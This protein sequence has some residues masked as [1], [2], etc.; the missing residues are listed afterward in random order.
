[1]S[2]L[3]LP[4]SGGV[5]S[6][7]HLSCKICHKAFANVYRLQRHMISHDESALL[8]KF[9]CNQCDKAF[10]FKHHLK[11]HVRI[12]SGEKPFGCDNCGKRFSHSG[13]YSSHMTSKKCISMG[14]K[15]NPNRA[16]LKALEKN[17]PGQNAKRYNANNGGAMNTSAGPTESS[18]NVDAALSAGLPSHMNYYATDASDVAMNGGT[19]PFYPNI[20]Q[21]YDDYNMNAMNAALLAAFPHP[22]YSL[23]LNPR[24]SPYNIQRL[25]ELTAV[26]QQH[27]HQQQ[28]QQQQ[29]VQQREEES[30]SEREQQQPQLEEHS[31]R[32]E[33]S[34]DETNEEEIPDEPKLVMDL[35]ESEA[36]EGDLD[37][38]EE[39][40]SQ[41]VA[42]EAEDHSY[43]ID[44]EK[45]EN[46]EIE[47]RQDESLKSPALEENEQ[48]NVRL[49][50]N[51]VSESTEQNIVPQIKLEENRPA[52]PVDEERADQVE[53]AKTMPVIKQELDSTVEMEQSRPMETSTPTSKVEQE[54]HNES[55]ACNATEL[56]CS[57]C[58]TQF[59]HQTELVQ[60]EK[61]LCGFIKQELQ[62]SY[63]EQH[64]QR[65]QQ[66]HEEELQQPQSLV[67][68][69][70]SMDDSAEQS[71]I[72]ATSLLHTSDAEDY[73]D[74]RDSHSRNDCNSEGS[75]RKVRVRT[76]I[77]EEQQQQLKQHYA[78]NAR[79]SREEFRMIAAR[80]QLDARVVQ[81]WF[82][83]NRSRERKMQNYQQANGKLPLAPTEASVASVS[84]G[85]RTG[86]EQP[87]DLSLKRDWPVAA[88]RNGMQQQHSPLYGIAPM[89]SVS[90]SSDFTEAINLSR[91]MSASM[92]PP[93]SLSPSSAAS[94]P[95]SLKQHA[96]VYFG[97]PSGSHHFQRRTPSP[98]E[99]P[100]LTQQQPIA[101]RSVSNN[102]NNNSF[103]ASLAGHLPPYMLPT[104]AQ[105]SMMPMDA[106][107]RMTPGDYACNPLINS[108]KFPDYRGTSL[109]PGGSEKRSWRDDDSRISHDDDYIGGGLLPKPKR[110]KAE[111]HGHAGDPDLPFV[112]DQC[113]KAFA[114]Q[115]SL[116]RHKYEHSGQRPYQC[117]DCP[118]A[119][120]HKHH[121]TEHKRLH[122]GEKPFQ[123]SKCFKRFSHSGSYSQ[124]MNHRYSYCKPYRE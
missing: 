46:S 58:D 75:E 54:S 53:S 14:M 47:A 48:T 116:A 25:L 113:D 27:Q 79:P 121:L 10:K 72:S 23:G 95:Q 122:S 5:P 114:K 82:Q 81:V 50:N 38:E 111:T 44:E 107:F 109:S 62:H 36:K 97:A 49:E 117:V 1:M 77:T 92:S 45:I 17:A 13:S 16:M 110:P 91:K 63:Q 119:F 123:C 39:V 83:N 51:E 68:S 78:M 12:H 106:I 80:L 22:F 60:H 43:L 59:N 99:A 104:G 89:Q 76:A 85:L 101:P 86:E 108:I 19:P 3:L 65:L 64:S 102:N 55:S 84:T 87:L 88:K 21:K 73:P 15:L 37:D 93:S 70:H 90:G 4:S 33:D 94:V 7:F 118:K 31:E 105:R 34:I 8:R 2:V 9:K 96:A 112:C 103:S 41:K 29:E 124:H 71:A 24:L 42:S 66:E 57:R 26:G 120:K 20:L 30:L 100:S 74:E 61:V 98:N 6:S 35:D 69:Q 52:T 56:R 40:Q 67:R 32:V 28:E 115:S 11:E 18:L